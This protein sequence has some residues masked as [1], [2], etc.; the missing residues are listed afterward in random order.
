MKRANRRKVVAALVGTFACALPQTAVAGSKTYAL[1]IGNNEPPPGADGKGLAALR[2][3]DD[4]AVRYAELLGQFS[5]DVRLVTVLD[6]ESRRRY[7]DLRPSAPP[8]LAAVRRQLHELVEQASVAREAGDDVTFFVVFS[9]HGAVRDSGEAVLA[10]LDT[11]LTR[12][13]LF[14]DILEPI[15]A[16]TVHLVLDA[17][18]AAGVVG[19]RGRKS[20]ERELDANSSEVS[21]AQ[22]NGWVERRTLARFPHVGVLAATTA[23]EQ[24]H[25]WSEI[26]SGVFSHEVLSAL[27]GAA[28]VN[29]DQT[30]EYTEV[31]AFVAAANRTLDDPRAAPRV[32]ARPPATDPHAP[33]VDMSTMTS[34]TWI[35][36]DAS[37]LGHF[38]VELADGRRHLDANVRVSAT[39]IAIPSGTAAFVRTRDR[40]AA[41]P[42]GAQKVALADL[43]FR[44]PTAGSRGSTAAAY[45]RKL[46]AEPLTV[47]YYR[48]YVDSIEGTPVSFEAGPVQLSPKAQRTTEPEDLRP[49]PPVPTN[50]KNLRF[51]DAEPRQFDRSRTTRRAG[52]AFA[53]L[54]AGAGLATIVT[55][56]LAIKARSDFNATDLEGPSNEASNRHFRY[57]IG[58][59]VSAGLT[60][61][62]TGLA[63]PLLLRSRTKK[64][65]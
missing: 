13:M 4:D 29:G 58:A 35:S 55:A 11:S 36:G 15:D 1:V 63:I 6:H 30:I 23:G 21:R 31:Q 64:K 24:A 45:K 48:G 41:L 43:A 12:T 32:V 46:F 37:R 5:E 65:Q 57:S 53:T 61:V 62:F 56:A 42:V 44:T 49:P 17:C 3:A 20:F 51:D 8:R 28:D 54:A 40:E 47:D 18:H 22:A 34:S 2:Y 9:G 14:D 59:G 25:E 52:V 39:T 7:P 38:T 50:A 60:A 16:D 10:L 33:L 27:W 26:E 19:V